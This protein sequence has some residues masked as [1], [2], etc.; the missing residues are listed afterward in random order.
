L[1]YSR[2]ATGYVEGVVPPSVLADAYKASGSDLK[3]RFLPTADCIAIYWM[4]LKQ[5]SDKDI[6]IDLVRK[7]NGF[8]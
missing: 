8:P 5:T 1:T 4:G 6:R 3:F 2:V 7:F